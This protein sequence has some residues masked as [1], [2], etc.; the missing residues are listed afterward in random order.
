[1][2]TREQRVVLVG[3]VLAVPAA[4]LVYALTGSVPLAG[5]T[6]LGLG[7]VIPSGINGSRREEGGDGDADEER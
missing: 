6:L 1:M 5:A 2:V 4:Y 3:V 7:F